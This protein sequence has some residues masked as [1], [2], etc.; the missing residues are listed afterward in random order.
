MFGNN[1]R[2]VRKNPTAPASEPHTKKRKFYE[3][4]Q[5]PEGETLATCEEHKKALIKEMTKTKKNP[6]LIKE[7][8]DIT[9][10]HRRQKLLNETKR[11]ETILE[12]YPAL[13]LVS[14]VIL[15]TH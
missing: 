3:V 15:L 4:P 12:E 14:E 13:Q 6:H 10:A 7:L 9:F 1:S 5:L 11:V 8:M 2:P